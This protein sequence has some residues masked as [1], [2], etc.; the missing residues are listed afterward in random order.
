MTVTENVLG[1]HLKY[2]DGKGFSL[3]TLMEPYKIALNTD[4]RQ[5][6]GRLFGGDVGIILERI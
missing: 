6:Q 5:K 3:N 1:L 4:N 2:C